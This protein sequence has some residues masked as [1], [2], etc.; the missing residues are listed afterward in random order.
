MASKKFLVFFV[1]FFLVLIVCAIVFLQLN[2][3][4]DSDTFQSS[5]TQPN[6]VFILTDDQRVD[7]LHYMPNV[8][9]LV[10]SQGTTFVNGYV[11]TSLCCPSRASILTGQYAHNHNVRSN[12]APLGGFDVFN[13]RNTLP[14]WLTKASYTTGLFGKYL[15]GYKDANY[16]PPGWN[17]WNAFVESKGKNAKEDFYYNYVLSENGKSVNYGNVASDYSTD[18]LVT[19]VNSFIENSEK[20]DDKPFFVYFVPFAPHKPAIPAV[21]HVTLFNDV[22]TNRS[23]SFNEEVSDKPGWIQRLEPLSDADRNSID[24]LRK[25]RIRSL[26]AV[27]EAVYSIIDTLKK[28]GELDNTVIIFMSD[29]GL[30]LGEHSIQG[31][32]NVAYEESIHVPF[33]IADMRQG[34]QQR[35]SGFALNIDVAPTILELAGANQRSS[36]DGRSLVPFIQGLPSDN[37][38]EDFLF[39]HWAGTTSSSPRNHQGVHSQNYVYIEYSMTGEREFYDLSTDPYQLT[40]AVDDSTYANEIVDLKARLNKLKKCSGERC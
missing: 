30:L 32:K 21:R 26:Q 23:P 20:N 11:T 29:N 31:E 36:I 3:F 5:G 22:P 8:K 13:D 28:N 34:L 40:N 9:Q 38:R 6:I 33:I 24:T 4:L 27:D 12:L 2:Y 16:I 39:E 25:N 19:K 15:N 35:V 14:V 10:E 18:V 7:E 37:W 17:E 1:A